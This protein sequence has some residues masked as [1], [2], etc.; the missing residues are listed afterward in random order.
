MPP[1][2]TEHDNANHLFEFILVQ[3]AVGVGVGLYIRMKDGFHLLAKL[4]ESHAVLNLPRLS[5]NLP[6]CCSRI[7]VSRD[8]SVELR[9]NIESLALRGIVD[10][11]QEPDPEMAIAKMIWPG[12]CNM[13]IELTIAVI[14]AD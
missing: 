1:V 4:G 5:R 14:S 11:R 8:S 7:H 12:N 13:T 2:H 6:E 9:R 10:F 3:I